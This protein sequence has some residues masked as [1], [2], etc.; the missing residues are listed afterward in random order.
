MHDEPPQKDSPQNRQAALN[1]S[2]KFLTIRQRSEKEI[3]D[4]LKKKGFQEITINPT[5][6]KLIELKFIDDLQFAHTLTDQRQRSSGRGKIAIQR[7]LARKGIEKSKIDEVLPT[8][9]DDYN[10]AKQVF[11]KYSYRFEGLDYMSYQRKAGGFL[12][13]RG[14]SYDVIKKVLKEYKK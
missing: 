6:E 12:S 8:K 9:Q 14:F 13:R 4:F 10:T 7:E 11:E 2:L 3:R 5:I 1:K